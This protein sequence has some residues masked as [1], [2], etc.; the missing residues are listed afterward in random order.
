[1]VKSVYFNLT[2]NKI[3]YNFK[4]SRKFSVFY[5]KTLSK[6]YIDGSHNPLFC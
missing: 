5:Y 4:S 2:L 1:M 6:I 3:N